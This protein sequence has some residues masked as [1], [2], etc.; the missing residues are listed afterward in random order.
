[1]DSFENPVEDIGG[2]A[3]SAIAERSRAV[4]LKIAAV[5]A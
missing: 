3:A 2:Q 1:V 4:F 5:N